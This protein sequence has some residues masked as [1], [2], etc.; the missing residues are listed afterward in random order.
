M[1]A[2]SSIEDSV[3]RTLAYSEEGSLLFKPRNQIVLAPRCS[4]LELEKGAGDE[5]SRLATAE[6]CFSILETIQL[7]CS[8]NTFPKVAITSSIYPLGTARADDSAN[9]DSAHSNVKK[10]K[11]SLGI[12]KRKLEEGSSELCVARLGDINKKSAH[13]NLLVTPR[14]GSSTQIQAMRTR[15][16]SLQIGRAHV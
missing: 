4:V 6:A 16:E 2:G 1:R 3:Q 8:N 14:A 11:Q 10:K 7:P 5:W 9:P 12:F 13:H 15:E